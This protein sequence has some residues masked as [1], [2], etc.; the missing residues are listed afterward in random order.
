MDM[1]LYGSVQANKDMD[2]GIPVSE[3]PEIS[4]LKIAVLN[5]LSSQSHDN[6]KEFSKVL[7]AYI[8]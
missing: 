1:T 7:K 2:M 8:C 3:K 6:M 5:L 4:E